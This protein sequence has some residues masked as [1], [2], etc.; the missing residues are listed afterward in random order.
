MALW[1]LGSVADEIFNLI[2]GI[3]ASISGATLLGII[4]RKRYFMEQWIGTTIGSVD[5]VEKYQLPL[6]NLSSADLMAFMNVQGADVAKIKL[7]ELSVEKGGG[8]TGTSL[9][10]SSAK[11]EQEAMIMLRDLKGRYNYFKALG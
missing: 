6:L 3:P 11:L 5:I 9:L 8:T 7:G 4:D 2:D 10:A 1:N